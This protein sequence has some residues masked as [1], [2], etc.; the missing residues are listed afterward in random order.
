MRSKL[1][2]VFPERMPLSVS[3]SVCVCVCVYP[4]GCGS[5]QAAPGDQEHSQAGPGDGG[6]APRQSAPGGG[7]GHSTGPRQQRAQP[8]RSGHGKHGRAQ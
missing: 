3:L 1:S 4:R 8:E 6:A 2:L 7:P 5:E